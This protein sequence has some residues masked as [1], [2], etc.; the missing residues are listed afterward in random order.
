VSPEK[1]EA[2]NTV[3]LQIRLTIIGGPPNFATPQS[4]SIGEYR[5]T[6]ISRNSANGIIS[7]RVRIP[8]SAETG[9]ATVFV[10]FGTGPRGE[11]P[12]NLSLINGFEIE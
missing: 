3:V 7:A 2:G 11:P 1:G 8:N 5:G 4:V 12:L 10:R 6:N 9:K